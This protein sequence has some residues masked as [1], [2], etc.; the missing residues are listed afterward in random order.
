MDLDHKVRVRVERSS[1][2]SLTHPSHSRHIFDGEMAGACTDILQGPYSIF[3]LRNYI[4]RRAG[5]AKKYL[6]CAFWRVL[7]AYVCLGHPLEKLVVSAFLDYKSLKCL[8]VETT[9]VCSVCA[10]SLQ[11]FV[12]S[13]FCHYKSVKCPLFETTKVCRVCAF[14]LQKFVVSAF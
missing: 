9:K 6:R 2:V 1:K 11:K 12:A 8:L 4:Q 14:S 7:F 5:E 13:A 3:S 10:F